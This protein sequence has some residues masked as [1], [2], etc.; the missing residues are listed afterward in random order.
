MAFTIPGMAVLTKIEP[1]K[2]MQTPKP[3]TINFP[4]KYFYSNI[5]I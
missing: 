2:N 4:Q 3:K 5:N 1:Q